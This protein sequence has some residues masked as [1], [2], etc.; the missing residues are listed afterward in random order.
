[1]KLDNVKVELKL[2]SEVEDYCK[3]YKGLDTAIK[4]FIVPDFLLKTNYKGGAQAYDTHL[5]FVLWVLSNAIEDA[6]PSDKER[7]LDVVSRVDVVVMSDAEFKRD[8]PD[9]DF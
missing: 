6:W 9:F 4:R 1:M 3:K 8:H 2:G 7:Y 5:G